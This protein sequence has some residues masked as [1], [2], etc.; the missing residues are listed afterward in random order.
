MPKVIRGHGQDPVEDQVQDLN[1]EVRI[2][3]HEKHLGKVR[4]AGEGIA[5]PSSA[6]KDAPESGLLHVRMMVEK[7][8]GERGV[9]LLCRRF[10]KPEPAQVVIVTSIDPVKGADRKRGDSVTD[11]RS[12]A[13]VAVTI[14][15]F[16]G[17]Q[18]H[19]LMRLEHA[20]EPAFPAQS[21][22]VKDDI[23]HRKTS[24]NGISILQDKVFFAQN[25]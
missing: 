5:R 7:H 4:D 8:Q 9:T 24:K 2:D 25:G 16:E 17:C 3:P 10:L 23:F 22:H 11:G 6:G 1:L 20:F 13:I 12:G 19:G 15:P 18:V 14:G 21:G